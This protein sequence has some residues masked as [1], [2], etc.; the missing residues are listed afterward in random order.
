M[1]VNLLHYKTWSTEYEL[2]FFTFSKTASDCNLDDVEELCTAE[3]PTVEASKHS[4]R[5]TKSLHVPKPLVAYK[6]AFR[7]TATY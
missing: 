4:I 5:L 6:E 2:F 7:C 3:Y 1:I